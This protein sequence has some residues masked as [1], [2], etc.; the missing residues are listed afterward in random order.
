M[1]DYFPCLKNMHLP[2]LITWSKSPVTTRKPWTV[3]TSLKDACYIST[4]EKKEVVGSGFSLNLW[5]VFRIDPLFETSLFHKGVGTQRFLCGHKKSRICNQFL[6][7]GGFVLYKTFR[8]SIG[9]GVPDRRFKVRRRIGSMP[10]IFKSLLDR[11][12]PRLQD[13]SGNKSII[14]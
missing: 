8:W 14:S 6:Y 7:G 3:I 2:L 13:T 1:A 4:A 12:A 10:D 5:A 11:G 9:R